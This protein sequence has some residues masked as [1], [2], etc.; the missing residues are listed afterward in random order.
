M[1]FEFIEM[2]FDTSSVVQL[3][4]QEPLAVKLR[5]ASACA[6]VTGRRLALYG[7]TAWFSAPPKVGEAHLPSGWDGKCS[8]PIYRL[9]QSVSR[10]RRQM[11]LN[12]RNGSLRLLAHA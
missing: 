10:S 4:C 5:T 6:V 9:V 2:T 8:G 11:L 3:S 1:H 12:S 7:A